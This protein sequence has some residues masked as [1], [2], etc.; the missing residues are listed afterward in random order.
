M[1]L[2]GLAVLVAGYAGVYKAAQ[3]VKRPAGGTAGSYLYWLT[4]IASLG[5][6]SGGV[7]NPGA[8]TLLG[9]RGAGGAADQAYRDSTG[10]NPGTV[11]VPR[12]K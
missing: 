7:N 12:G 4:G 9:A 10:Q 6:P 1:Q 3:M 11:G 5:A 2:V 8:R